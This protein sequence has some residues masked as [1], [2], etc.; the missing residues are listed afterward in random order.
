M[1]HMRMNV[2]HVKISGS[3]T[4]NPALQMKVPAGW[5][6]P[7]IRKAELAILNRINISQFK[8]NNIEIQTLLIQNAVNPFPLRRV[9]KLLEICQ[10]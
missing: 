1:M 7:K 9:M 2:E 8:F 4:K 10:S 5:L 6:D 3:F